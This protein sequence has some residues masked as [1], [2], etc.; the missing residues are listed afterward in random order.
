MFSRGLGKQT[1]NNVLDDLFQQVFYS[2]I[3]FR[4]AS[5]APFV[6]GNAIACFAFSLVFAYWALLVLGQELKMKTFSL[7]RLS[8]ISLIL[9][10]A[11]SLGTILLFFSFS[12]EEKYRD[13]PLLHHCIH[14]K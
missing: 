11:G 4:F 12:Q 10:L 13:F 6:L 14:L 1:W 3:R 8:V 7:K 2:K 9:V 5:Y